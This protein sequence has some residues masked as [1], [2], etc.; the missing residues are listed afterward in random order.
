M[1]NFNPDDTLV[2]VIICAMRPRSCLSRTIQSVFQSEYR[3]IEV[4]V[5]DTTNQCHENKLHFHV[6][7]PFLY[8]YIPCGQTSLPDARNRGIRASNGSV[9]LFVTD[10]C[11]LHPFS[12]SEHVRLHRSKKLV[13]V[14]GRTKT[15]IAQSESPNGLSTKETITIINTNA[16][17]GENESDIDFLNSA[18]LSIKRAVLHKTGLFSTLFRG[19]N[20]YEINDFS[21][22]LKKNGIALR[23]APGA[24]AYRYETPLPF[25]AVT[26]ESHEHVDALHNHALYYFLHHSA[27]PS[28][29][30]L[31]HCFNLCKSGCLTSANKRFSY[32]IFNIV[33]CMA[34]FS[35]AYYAASKPRI[36]RL[37][38]ESRI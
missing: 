16:F 6:Q 37:F 30:L 3:T 27:I 26:D 14:A 20:G 25:Q 21:I 28:L 18:H 31:W 32:I 23:Y 12:I 1:A 2:S 33:R 4:I 38:L 15:M 8:S 17:D 7:F 35:H 13:A 9:L 36:E 11:L 34:A 29:V 24:V 22:K 19:F 10:D 5:I